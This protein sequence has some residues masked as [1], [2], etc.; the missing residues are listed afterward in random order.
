MNSACQSLVVIFDI[1]TLLLETGSKSTETGSVALVR[2]RVF[3]RMGGLATRTIENEGLCNRLIR[4][5]CRLGLFSPNLAACS[6][7]M[8]LKVDE[9]RNVA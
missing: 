2:L 9:A 1:Q 3:D 8:L 4:K 7:R 6:L 5:M